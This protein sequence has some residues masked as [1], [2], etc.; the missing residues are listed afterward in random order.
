MQGTGS[1][2]TRVGQSSPGLSEE[3]GQGGSSSALGQ[4][5]HAPG[6]S[7]Q[8]QQQQPRWQQ[9][10][11]LEHTH[12]WAEGH[13]C[14]CLQPAHPASSGAAGGPPR[15]ARP[16]PGQHLHPSRHLLPQQGVWLFLAR[17]QSLLPPWV[18]LL[19]GRHFQKALAGW[20]LRLLL[21]PAAL[22]SPLG[23]LLLYVTQLRPRVPHLG[24]L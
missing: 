8:Q 23:P 17:A 3:G 6:H 7:K 2:S 16:L 14:P 9:A 5:Q 20:W 19:F 11:V 15:L 13:G 10:A 21:P 4:S 18:Q 22:A 12:L 24:C 1:R